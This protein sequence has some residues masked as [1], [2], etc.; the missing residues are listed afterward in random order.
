MALNLKRDWRW[1]YLKWSAVNLTAGRLP[2]QLL[3]HTV[4]VSFL[5]G[6]PCVWQFYTASMFRGQALDFLGKLHKRPLW[7]SGRS[8]RCIEAYNFILH[9]EMKGSLSL[10][11]A[12]FQW[13]SYQVNSKCYFSMNR[14]DPDTWFKYE[15]QC[16][17]FGTIKVRLCIFDI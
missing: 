16:S 1:Q 11:N 6:R 7:F 3:G 15:A 9:L 8:L 13:E 2:P 12:L 17:I 4:N 14:Q 10:W 5:K